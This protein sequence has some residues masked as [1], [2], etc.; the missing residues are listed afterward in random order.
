VSVV[1]LIVA[2]RSII[3]K[4]MLRLVASGTECSIV[5]STYHVVSDENVFDYVCIFQLRVLSYTPKMCLCSCH[6]SGFQQSFW[7]VHCDT[8]N[9]AVGFKI[10]H[11]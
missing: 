11:H 1:R 8:H 10:R 9:Q 3:I 4:E 5:A 7:D 2:T 6:V